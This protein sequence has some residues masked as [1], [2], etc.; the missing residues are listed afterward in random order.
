MTPEALLTL[1]K[2]VAAAGGVGTVGALLKWFYD[3]ASGRSAR[4][5]ARVRSA[6]EA[7]RDAGVWADAYWRYRTWCRQAHGY[8]PD[9]PTP[10]DEDD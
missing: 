1:G 3:Q 4:K 5:T 2:W 7:M 6:I 9:A 8:D 10:P